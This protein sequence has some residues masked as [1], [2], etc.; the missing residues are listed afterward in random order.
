MTIYFAIFPTCIY[1]IGYV[2]RDVCNEWEPIAPF[3]WE[4]GKSRVKR[5]WVR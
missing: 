3:S 2:Y 5:W 4:R 1:R